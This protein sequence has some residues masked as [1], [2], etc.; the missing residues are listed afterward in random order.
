M[1]MHTAE[2][3]TANLFDGLTALSQDGSDL[4]AEWIDASDDEGIDSEYVMRQVM[5][6]RI[7]LEV[8]CWGRRLA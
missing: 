3:D 8:E 6:E 4:P 2:N 1:Q 5:N 7:D